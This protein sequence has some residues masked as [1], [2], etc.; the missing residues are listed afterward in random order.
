MSVQANPDDLN[1]NTSGQEKHRLAKHQ[2]KEIKGQH[3]EKMFLQ[4]YFNAFSLCGMQ[5]LGVAGHGC[6]NALSIIINNRLP[7]HV[8]QYCVQPPL[9]PDSALSVRV[10]FDYS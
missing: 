6:R 1:Q 5:L 8:R 10:Q 4:A 7:S 9:W 3:F 2:S